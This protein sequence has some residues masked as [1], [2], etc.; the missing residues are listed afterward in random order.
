VRA[1]A[2]QLGITERTVLRILSDLAAEG[3]LQKY[4]EARTNSYEVNHDQPLLGAQDKT[5][6]VG[7]LLK[8]LASAIQDDE[9]RRE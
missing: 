7:E 6:A 5:I 4:R 2:S 8:V 1:I 3:Y 9:E